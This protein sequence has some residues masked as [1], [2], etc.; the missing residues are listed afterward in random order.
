MNYKQL[1][2][3]TEVQEVSGSPNGGDDETSIM[4][5]DTVCIGT[6]VQMFPWKTM[7]IKNVS[8]SD[9]MV[10]MQPSTRRKFLSAEECNIQEALTAIVSPSGHGINV[11]IHN[12]LELKRRVVCMFAAECRKWYCHK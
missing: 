8:T 2:G 12:L 7:K 3:K 10:C 6:Q 4:G 1:S 9:T 11:F 5:H